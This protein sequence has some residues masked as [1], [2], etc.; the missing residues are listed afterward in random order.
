MPG[1]APSPS[2]YAMRLACTPPIEQ[3]ISTDARRYP[4][5][6]SD[7][8]KDFKISSGGLSRDKPR[9]LKSI[10]SAACIQNSM[11]AAWFL[12]PDIFLKINVDKLLMHSQL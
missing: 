6:P 1:G 8:C 4:S 2:G 9:E 11:D 7:I 5:V 12:L 3:H 10:P